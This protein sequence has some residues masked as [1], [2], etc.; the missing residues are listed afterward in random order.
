MSYPTAQPIPTSS[1]NSN[2]LEGPDFTTWRGPLTPDDT[3]DPSPHTGPACSEERTL[4]HLS[5]PVAPTQLSAQLEA[6]ALNLDSGAGGAW[7]GTGTGPSASAAE[8]LEWG[9]FRGESLYNPG[10]SEEVGSLVIGSYESHPPYLSPAS[11]LHP[12]PRTVHPPQHSTT[13]HG[14]DFG[15]DDENLSQAQKEE[16]RKRNTTASARFRVK[17]KEREKQLE[18]D[19]IQLRE[20]VASLEKEVH[21]LKHENSWLRELI[22]DKT[23]SEMSPSSKGD[24]TPMPRVHD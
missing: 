16:K 14:S 23:K 21:T 13:T 19:R 22:L 8:G 11:H 9:S 2:H 12:L 18:E 17:K 7:N 4:Q 10:L 20:K 3:P 24:E 5:F 15:G 1:N 6:W